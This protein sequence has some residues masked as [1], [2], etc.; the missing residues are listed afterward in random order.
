AG[1]DHFDLAA[2]GIEVGET[3][4]DFGGRTS[5]LGRLG[6]WLGGAQSGV[7]IGTGPPVAGLCPVMGP[8]ALLLDPESRKAPGK[9]GVIAAVEDGTVPPE[10]VIDVAIHTKGKTLDD[11]ARALARA[12]ALPGGMDV[13]IGVQR[14]VTAIR[15]INRRVTIMI[16]AL[17][18][19]ASGQSE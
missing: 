13:S 19:A 18:E 14:L 15:R 1:A 4:W 17:D 11:C 6:A 2:R 3:G 5:L 12:L 16:D 9:P 8:L 10:G 7:G